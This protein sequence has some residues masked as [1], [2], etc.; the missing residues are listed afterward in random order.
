MSGY[1]D[2]QGTM[3]PAGWQ[4]FDVAQADAW[5][6]QTTLIDPLFPQGNLPRLVPIA[7]GIFL[8][9]QR[10]VQLTPAAIALA[11]PSTARVQSPAE[12]AGQASLSGAGW[13]PWSNAPVPTWYMETALLNPNWPASGDRIYTMQG[14]LALGS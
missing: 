12:V 13:V 11:A 8:A 6:P 14:A 4:S 1:S 2:A 10:G 9:G 7:Q 5:G 3:V